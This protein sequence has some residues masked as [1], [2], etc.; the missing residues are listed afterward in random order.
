[1]TRE[2]IDPDT[3]PQKGLLRLD[4][5]EAFGAWAETQG[6]AIEPVPPKAWNQA[7]RLRRDGRFYVFYKR[8]GSPYV[9]TK[10]A[11]RELAWAWLRMTFGKGATC[12]TS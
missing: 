10:G 2:W 11:A 8:T 3:L 4:Q 6:W 1:M 9:S 5:L 7:F 12:E